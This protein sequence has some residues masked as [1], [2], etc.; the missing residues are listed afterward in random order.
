MAAK[1]KSIFAPYGVRIRLS[2][3]DSKALSADLKKNATRKP[4]KYERD[5]VARYSDQLSRF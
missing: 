2:K 3:S 1:I 4:N 5:L